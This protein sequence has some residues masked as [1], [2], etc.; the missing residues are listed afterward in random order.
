MGTR[1]DNCGATPLSCEFRL[2]KANG[3]FAVNYRVLTSYYLSIAAKLSAWVRVPLGS[4]RF[5]AR[6][7]HIDRVLLGTTYNWENEASQDH[8]QALQEK[9]R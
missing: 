8:A 5:S 3:C 4:A 6:A 7:W 9:E 1:I 2:L